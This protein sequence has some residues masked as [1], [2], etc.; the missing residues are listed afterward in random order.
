MGERDQAA[1]TVVRIL[2]PALLEDDTGALREWGVLAAR[3]LQHAKLWTREHGGSSLVRQA[4]S[5]ALL[6]STPIGQRGT[7]I[8]ALS[9]REIEVLREL[10]QGS[11]NKLIARA[12]QMTENTVK[13]HLKNIFHK[14]GIKHRAQATR[15]AQD[16]GLVG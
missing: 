9:T 5:Q 3:L 16:N 8:G 13:F 1:E 4:L 2:E 10:A 7:L 12:L 6:E 15:V 11:S 14:L